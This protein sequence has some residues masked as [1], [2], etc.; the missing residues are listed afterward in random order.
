MNAI[1][2]E[3]PYEIKED[4]VIHVDSDEFLY[5]QGMTLPEFL[6][7]YSEYQYFKFNWLM[8][9][10]NH[11]YHESLNDILKDEQN[12]KYFVANFKSM[13]KTSEITFSEDAHKFTKKSILNELYTNQYF[14]IHFSYRGIYDCYNK[15]YNQKLKNH[16]D[17]ND[18]MI[19]P[20]IIS[21]KI[22]EIPSRIMCYI[23]ALQN[24]VKKVNPLLN[25]R[26]E[27]KTNLELLKNFEYQNIELFSK[28]IKKLIEQN[29]FITLP[30]IQA[31]KAE[32]KI[33]Y[34]R[35]DKVI[36]L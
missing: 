35:L 23:S 3:K 16:A 30:I 32:T 1:L 4:Y 21:T 2:S 18:I 36:A 17:I 26:I 12:P 22:N 11:L 19:N 15:T 27:S 33:F 29:I 13:A 25:L 10:S 24:C 6:N 8:C 7:Q 31:P 9:P 5:L 34:K 20:E 14:I 28:R